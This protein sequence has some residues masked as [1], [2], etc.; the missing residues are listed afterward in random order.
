MIHG[1]GIVMRLLDK[2]G[3]EYTLRTSW[4]WSRTFTRSS[5]N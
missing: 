5:A 2:G 3:M 1:E 4:A